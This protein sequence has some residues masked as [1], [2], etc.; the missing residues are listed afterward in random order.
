VLRESWIVKLLIG[1]LTVQE[2]VSASPRYQMTPEFG[3]VT[4][5]TG[6]ALTRR[7]T[8]STAGPWEVSP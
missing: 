3:L 7:G 1:P 2:I 5:T 4:L 8:S 6:D